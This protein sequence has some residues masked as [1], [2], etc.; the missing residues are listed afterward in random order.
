M[1]AE[2][3]EKQVVLTKMCLACSQEFQGDFATCPKDGTALIALNR[4]DPY[5]GKVLADRYFVKEIIGKGGMG[6][7]YLA[8]HQM[9][10]RLV[11]L[12]MLQAELCQDEVS[13]RRFQQ[14]AKAAS[15]LAHP[16]VITLHDFGVMPTGQPFLVMEFLEGIP[17]LDILKQQGPMEPKRAVKIFSEAAEGLYHAHKQ[18]IVHRDLKPSNIIL[19]N[20]QGD[21]DFVKIVD[22]G[23]AKLMPWS[24]KESQHLTKTGEVFGSPI[25]MSPEQCMGKPLG[26]TSDIYSLGITLFEALTGKPPFRGSNSIQTASKHMQDPPPRFFDVRPD[27]ALPD[28][29]ERVVLKCLAKN[30]ADRFQDMAAF[31]DALQAGLNTDST[32]TPASLMVSTRA[33]PVIQ[34]D[35]AAAAAQSAAERGKSSKQIP[36]AD[37]RKASS[38]RTP[39]AQPSKSAFNPAIAGG[40]LAGL[41]LVAGGAFLVLVPET[42][43]TS[44]TVYYYATGPGAPNQMQVRTKDGDIRTFGFDKAPP[45]W[46]DDITQ[47]RLGENVEVT[48]STKRF[49]DKKT[50]DVSEIKESANTEQTKQIQSAIE[51]VNEFL[52]GVTTRDDATAAGKS[53]QK[54]V[55][56]FKDMIGEPFKTLANIRVGLVGVP[57]DAA[58]MVDKR[59]AHAFKIV[60]ADTTAGTT[61]VVV[62]GSWFTTKDHPYWQFTVHQTGDD[63]KIAAVDSVDEGSF[64]QP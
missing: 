53:S 7:V 58:T 17:L 48:Y 13:V 18:G 34:A 56:Q 33:I 26:P 5:I 52:I 24:G 60:D 50:G 54:L 37:P 32:Q 46:K 23:L 51:L 36:V 22:F 11:A 42:A 20:H 15:A 41:L 19:I 16:H 49:S 31:R 21:P 10:D 61:K 9:M 47:S 30:P 4:E 12:K 8:R 35:R 59:P 43:T 1:G 40:A 57:N 39:V 55:K 63:V 44:G 27:L 6:V 45:T 29:L 28:G 3:V 38:A 2:G 64:L 62:D 25:Y 14:E